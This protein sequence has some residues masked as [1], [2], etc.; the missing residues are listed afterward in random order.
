MRQAQST[1]MDWSF[2]HNRRALQKIRAVSIWT[3]SSLPGLRG[4]EGDALS[5]AVVSSWGCSGRGNGAGWSDAAAIVASSCGGGA[6]G[7][8]ADVGTCATHCSCGEDQSSVSSRSCRGSRSNSTI[9][10]LMNIKYQV[11]HQRQTTRRS[12]ARMYINVTPNGQAQTTRTTNPLSQCPVRAQIQS[13]LPSSQMLFS[14]LGKCPF[15]VWIVQHSKFISRTEKHAIRVCESR[16]S[17]R[18]ARGAP[19]NVI[20]TS[21]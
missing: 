3:K 15:R 1:G 7:P 18:R 13:S 10:S 17:H 2:F 4:D 20:M 6:A 19:N 5:R 14:P 21:K 11:P 16:L 12:T 8:G 9:R